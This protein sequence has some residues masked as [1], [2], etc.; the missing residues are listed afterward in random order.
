MP[1]P[2]AD[3]NT[4][5]FEAR[6]ARVRRLARQQDL[7]LRKSRA[8]NPLRRDFGAYVLLDPRHNA[9]IGPSPEDGW[10]L[11]DIES[12]LRAR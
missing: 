9:I 4:A 5:A 6:E 10:G 3:E 11:E 8:R 1:Y 2:F 12:H 7:L